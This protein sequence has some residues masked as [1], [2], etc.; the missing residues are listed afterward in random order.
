MIAIHGETSV[1]LHRLRRQIRGKLTPHQSIAI[2]I[3]LLFSSAATSAQTITEF[4]IPT[5]DSQPN[6][7]APGPDGNLWFLE[8]AGNRVAKITISGTVTEFPALPTAFSGPAA[9][10]AGPDGA[11]WFAEFGNGAIGRISTAGT[12]TEFPIP[13]AGAEPSGIALGPDGNLWFTELAFDKIGRI[14]PG[15]TVTEFPLSATGNGFDAITAGPN[16]NLW[17][18]ESN[19]DRIGQITTAGVITEFPDLP[20]AEASPQSIVT[21]PDGNL[22]FTENNAGQIG[23]ITPGGTVTE[24][25]LPSSGAPAAITLGPDGALWFTDTGT[26]SIGRITTSGAVSE[27]PVPTA[28]SDLVGIAT[29]PDG[30]L[31]FV[32]QGANQ[33]GRL[34]PSGAAEPAPLFSA[35]LPGSRSVQVGHPATI[36]ATILNTATTA[37]TD[38]GIA[39]PATSPAGLTLQYQATN[40]QTN[41][42]IG[43]VNT[44]VTIGP[45]GAQTYVIGFTAGAPLSAPGYAPIFDCTDVAAAPVTLGVNTVDLTFSA[46]PI[47]DIIALSATES[48]N[49]IVTIPFSQGAGAAFAVASVNAGAAA[50]LTVTADTG[51]ASLPIS[52]AL[53]QTNPANAECLAPPATSVPVTIAAGATPTF[54]IFVSATAAV[55]FEPGTSRIFVRFLDAAGASHGSTSVAVTTD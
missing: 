25:P 36:F 27:F 39:A 14:T 1:T 23:R 35:T 32:E 19:A 6:F 22:W 9:I 24:F 42:V 26:N 31:W 5:T 40:P 45:G 53:C 30:A 54:S 10:T 15:G 20:T 8:N 33:I 50:S 41:Q 44:P 38:C 46:G 13:T 18:T 2:A 12:L 3:A 7:I 52:I 37:Q 47:A 21:G 28:A 48:G 4:P 29:G 55:A 16:G 49:G 51:S 11:L 17:F 34:V 43:T